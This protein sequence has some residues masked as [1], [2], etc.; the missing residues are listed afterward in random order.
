MMAEDIANGMKGQWTLK[1]HSSSFDEFLKFQEVG[2]VRRR[3]GV[4]APIEKT[5]NFEGTRFEGMAIVGGIFKIADCLALDEPAV[6]DQVDGHDCMSRCYWNGDVFVIHKLCERRQTE[7]L[8]CHSW[9]SA[10]P[11]VLVVDLIA[12]SLDGKRTVSTQDIFLRRSKA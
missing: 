1:S 11:A 7:V 10:T 5:M 8:F 12:R 3:I 6:P 9:S 4:A 2:L